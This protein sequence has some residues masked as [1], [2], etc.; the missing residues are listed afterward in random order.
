[1]ENVLDAL[2]WGTR[3]TKPTHPPLCQL[4][5]EQESPLT[6]PFAFTTGQPH[7]YFRLLRERAPI[8]W[9]PIE[10]NDGF[11][12]LTRYE[13]VKYVDMNPKL[14]SSQRGGIHMA[15]A[16][17]K[18]SIE[19]RLQGAAVNNLICLDQPYH[20]PLRMHQRP[21]FT[22]DFVSSLRDKVAKEVDRLLDNMEAS[23]PRLN[24]VDYFSEKLPLFTLSEMLGVDEKDRPKIAR[25]MHYLELA[26]VTL[27]QNDG[28]RENK[29][30]LLFLTKF[31]WN[32]RQMFR[33]GQKV[34]QDRRKNPRDDLLTA[35]A[36][37]QFDG[38][39]MTQD[40]L[41]GSWLLIIFAGNDTTRNSL[42]GTM[43]LLSQ[44]PE[45]KTAFIRRPK[46]D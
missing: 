5:K 1:M 6:H 19:R 26:Q 32:V 13:D 35:I 14:F 45:S 7:D 4:P 29:T 12:A 31:L 36:Q 10:N 15:M 24:M 37:A 28:E 44:F 40:F 3:K 8:S 21:F 2:D 9:H 22:P 16:P 43:R 38:E 20:I 46:L 27:A 41:D 11:W 23:G 18:N 25:W 34:M 17:P 42:S 30:S 39:D 33:Y